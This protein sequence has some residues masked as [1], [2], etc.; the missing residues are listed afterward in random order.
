LVA[1]NIKQTLVRVPAKASAGEDNLLDKKLVLV[2]ISDNK[3]STRRQENKKTNNKQ[4]NRLFFRKARSAN[5]RRDFSMTV[6]EILTFL[7]NFNTLGL[8]GCTLHTIHVVYRSY[9]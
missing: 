4:N 1:T 9:R 7:Q 5:S 6:A 3:E 2:Q 8:G